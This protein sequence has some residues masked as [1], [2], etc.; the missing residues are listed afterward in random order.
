MGNSQKSQDKPFAAAEIAKRADA[1]LRVAL[2]TPP[3]PH[4]PTGK[5]AKSPERK[6][7]ASAKPKSA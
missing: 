6:H 1:A 7:A 3:K 4:K 5:K 2:A